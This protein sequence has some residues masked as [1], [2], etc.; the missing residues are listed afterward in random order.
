MQQTQEVTGNRE[1]RS[2][3]RL[4]RFWSVVLWGPL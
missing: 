2:S 1:G 3:N 4:N